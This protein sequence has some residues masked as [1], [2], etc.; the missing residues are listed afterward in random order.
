MFYLTSSVITVDGTP[1]RT[2]GISGKEVAICDVHTDRNFV[3]A[4]VEHCN[5]AHLHELH[6]YDVVINALSCI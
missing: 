6:L 2:Y 5:A 4:L 1:Y 3:Q